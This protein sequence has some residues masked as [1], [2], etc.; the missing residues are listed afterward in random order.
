MNAI[1]ATAAIEA[2]GLV[3]SYGDARAVDGLDLRVATGESFALLG[4]NGAGKT[5]T[6]GMLTTLVTPD[7]GTARV[8]GADVVREARRVREGIGIVFQDPTLDA[9]LTVAENLR[10]HAMLYD[11]PRR[12][13]RSRIDA[14]LERFGLADRRDA[15]VRTLSG[16]LRRRV[17]LVRSLVHEPRVLFLDEPTIGLDPRARAA[18]ADV[19]D[20]LRLEDEL[21]VVLTTH[22][23]AEADDCTRVAIMDAGRLVACDAPATLRASHGPGASLDDVFLALTGRTIT[24]DDAT[25][26]RG[27]AGRLQDRQRSGPGR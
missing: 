24:D 10:F 5:T 26:S 16:G 6:L 4:P 27:D 14:L 21:T 19:L 9:H 7:A 23:L 25:M 8:A 17:E 12:H 18:F 1:E 15:L 3:K 20:E 11:L 22:Y 2:S 13:A